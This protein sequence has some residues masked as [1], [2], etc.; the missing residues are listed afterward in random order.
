V[1]AIT[2]QVMKAWDPK[3]SYKLTI[4]PEVFWRRGA[5]PERPDLR[6]QPEGK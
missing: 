2:R 5:P 3:K 1:E 6:L 4:E